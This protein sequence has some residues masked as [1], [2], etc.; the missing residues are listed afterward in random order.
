MKKLNL[1]HSDFKDIIQNNNYFVD[2]TLFIEEVIKAQKA[3]LLFPRPRRFG[4]TLNLSMLRYFFDKNEPE[5][6]KLFKDLKIWQSDD[7]VKE[8]CCK[9]PVIYL[10]FKDA[11]A[12]TWERTFNHIKLEISNAYKAHRYLQEGDVLFDDEKE[13]FA[14]LINRKADEFDCEISLMQLCEYLQRYHNQ[15]VVVLIDEYDAPIQ[16]GY[17]KFYKEVISFMRNF[18][19]GAFK[20]NSNLYKGVITGILKISKESIFSGLNNIDTYSVFNYDFAD[21]FGF[22]EKEIKEI[23]IDFKLNTNHEQ[24]KKW[25]NGYRFGQTENIYNPWSILSYVTKHK[26]GLQPFWTKTSTNELIKKEI[27]KKDAQEIRQEISKLINNQTVKKDIEDNFVFP[28]I[29]TKKDLFWSLL[30]YSGY[31][32]SVSKVSRKRYE[33][34]I[35]NYELKTVFQDTIIEWINIDLKI[36][37][38]LLENTTEYL[39]TNQIEKFENGFRKIMG[40][41]FSYY[42]TTKINE[43]VYHSYILGLL[44][45]IGDDYIIKSNKESGEGRYDIMLI[46]HDRTKYGIVIEIKQI[47]KQ[48][49]K[50]QN[51]DF[52]KRI[53]EQIE[54]AENQIDK[55]KYYKELI[56]SKIT[57]EKIIKVP[58]VFAGKEAYVLQIKEK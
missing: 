1:G 12:D 20:D 53:N 46:P 30:I 37:K 28:D 51:K 47:E 19:S 42:D 18:L 34:K 49:K 8:H 39:I 32:T 50:E 26:E 40:D 44:A 2:K 10:S 56:D 33:L 15:K 22:T 14:K 36:Q 3:V 25:Y 31:L 35:P 4:K 7:K 27:K 57:E 54:I 17:D 5:N 52:Y 45:I 13:T 23:L 16:V 48:K 9:Y 24:V 58:I 6:E 41:T 21:K 55:N 43:Y 11:K 29:D 38:T